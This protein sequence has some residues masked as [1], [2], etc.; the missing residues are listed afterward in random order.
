M[1]LKNPDFLKIKEQELTRACREHK[2]PLTVQRRAILDA[3]AGRTDHPTADMV[4]DAVTA[5]MK[6]ISRTTI[7]RVLETLVDIGV[8]RKICNPEAKARFDADTSRHHHMTCMRCGKV[9]DIR[10]VEL[11]DL[12]L[13]ADEQNRYVLLD[14]SISFTGLCGLCRVQ[15]FGENY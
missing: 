6:G 5:T 2:L 10:R 13:P 11:N 12:Q 14:Y 8:V 7:Y 9:I 3:L 1:I 4:F 15:N